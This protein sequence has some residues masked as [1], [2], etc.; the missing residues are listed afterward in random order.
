MIGAM[1]NDLIKSRA[2]YF[3]TEGLIIFWFQFKNGKS[4]KLLRIQNFHYFASLWVRLGVILKI[5]SN[6]SDTWIL[7]IFKY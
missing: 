1:G 3:L 4:Y 5:V 6:I 7:K 2:I